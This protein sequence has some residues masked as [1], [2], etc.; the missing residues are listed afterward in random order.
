MIRRN[1]D[2]AVQY[3]RSVGLEPEAIMLGA[4]ADKAFDLELLD[5]CAYHGPLPPT[6]VAQRRYGDVPVLKAASTAP[7]YLVELHAR[8]RDGN[9]TVHVVM[10]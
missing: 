10:A 7:N 8:G 1:I 3:A 2:R 9:H 6:V 5:L 4:E